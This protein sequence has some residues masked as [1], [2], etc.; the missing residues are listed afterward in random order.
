MESCTVTF[1]L[2]KRISFS[3]RDKDLHYIKVSTLSSQ[4][5]RCDSLVVR[6]IAVTLKLTNKHLDCL[7][8]AILTSV[9]QRSSTVLVFRV[10]VTFLKRS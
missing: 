3:H 4:M 1:V 8:V 7:R 6:C 2:A 5:N 9:V 10:K